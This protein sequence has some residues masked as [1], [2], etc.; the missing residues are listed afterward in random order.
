MWETIKT[1]KK[2]DIERRVVYHPTPADVVEGE[3][4]RVGGLTEATEA[5]AYDDDNSPAGKN[6]IQH[7]ERW[8]ESSIDNTT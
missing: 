7:K 3:R 4:S 2:C 1:T 6:T 5:E 8:S